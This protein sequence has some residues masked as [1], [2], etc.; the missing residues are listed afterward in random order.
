MKLIEWDERLSIDKGVIDEDH[1]KLIEII[2]R[3]LKKDG[4]YE[5]AQELVDILDE[6]DA[7]TIEHFRNEENLQRISGFPDRDTHYNEHLRLT[8]T[9]EKLREE[10]R[11]TG[12]SYVNVMG[13]KV[14][15]FLREWLFDHIFK[16]D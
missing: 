3:F 5:S 8:C 15:N 11:P 10:V 7:Y 14:G 13:E 12:G 6:L 4:K 9:L 2:N 16:S 1:Q